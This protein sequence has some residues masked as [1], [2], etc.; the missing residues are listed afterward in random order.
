M[1][2]QNKT[3]N[4]GAKKGDAKTKKTNAEN[5]TKTNETI[6]A[7]P[8]AHRKPSRIDDSALIYVKSNTFGG[9]T[10]V[11]KRSGETIDWKFC[12]DV[13]PV[14]MSLLRAIKASA[15]IFFTENKILVDSVDDGEHTPED[16]YNALA[17]GRYYKDII[18]PD[19]FQKVCGWSV[20]DI[21]KKVPLLTVTAKENLVIALNTFIEDGTLDSLKKI[22]AFEEALGCN[23]MKSER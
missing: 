11:D 10:F 13:Q 15:A 4:T 18:D 2:Q 12:G 5:Q 23:L 1:A 14:S 8:A 20:N 3:T 17:V 9:L 16:V 6:K 22:R 21:E 7:S 19:D